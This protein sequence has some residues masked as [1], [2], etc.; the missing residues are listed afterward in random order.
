MDPATALVGDLWD[1]GDGSTST[2]RVPGTHT[3]TTAGVYTVTL[4]ATDAKGMADPA[5]PTR[6]ITVYSPYGY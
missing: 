6:A 4:T 3:Y 5:P 2:A 1:F